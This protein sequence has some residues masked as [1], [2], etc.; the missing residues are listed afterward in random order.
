LLNVFSWWKPGFQF[1]KA[2]FKE[3]MEY[4]S[5]VLG[6]RIVNY[7]NVNSPNFIIGKVLGVA[8]L[9][10]Y[11]IAYQ[12]VEF[13]VQRISKNVLRVMFPAFSKLQD[14]L[15]NFRDLYKKTVY[16][17][18]LILV[19]VFSGLII[20]AP[21]L[22]ELFYGSKWLPA[23]LPL[24]LLAVAGFC[25]SVWIST[26]VI[27]LSK[28][29][30]I[31]ELK[32]NLAFAVVLIPS[33]IISSKFGLVYVA[34]TVA[35]CTFVSL[36]VAQFK[37]LQIID[38]PVIRFQK[39]YFLPLL[40]VASFTLI[41]IFLHQIGLN[42]FSLIFRL[43]TTVVVS[44]ICYSLVVSLFDRNIFKKLATFIGVGKS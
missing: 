1:E 10:Y 8:S 33:L 19:P 14:D 30:P 7:F 41:V 13:P 3:L 5:S 34:G 43:I 4:G 24:Q 25:R 11:N 40:G 28:G 6:S 26:S 21:E 36:L 35:V 29:F 20:T 2:A 39:I 31:I 42:E 12:L 27:F 17:L 37:A 18:L 16:H 44:I 22:I 38:L 15:Q 23:V 9:G 32:I